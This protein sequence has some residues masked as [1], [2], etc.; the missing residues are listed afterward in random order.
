MAGSDTVLKY[1]FLAT[2]IISRTL[3]TIGNIVISDYIYS[4]HLPWCKIST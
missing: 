4:S 3:M 1:N 2:E